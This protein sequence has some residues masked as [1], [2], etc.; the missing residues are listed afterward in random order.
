M[1]QSFRLKQKAYRKICTGNKTEKMFRNTSV[2]LPVFYFSGR[3]KKTNFI[4]KNLYLP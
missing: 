4:R 1:V 2:L 3:N